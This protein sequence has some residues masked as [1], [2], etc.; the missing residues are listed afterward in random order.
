MVLERV[1]A[2]PVERDRVVEDEVGEEAP[3]L[4]ALGRVA[5]EIE[6][7]PFEVLPEQLGSERMVLGPILGAPVGAFERAP[8]RILRPRVAKLHAECR[9]ARRYLAAVHEDATG[10]RGAIGR[11]RATS[12]WNS[13][14]PRD[15]GAAQPAGWGWEASEERVRA[16][17][18]LA[19]PNITRP[20][21]TSAT[22]EATKEGSAPR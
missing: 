6:P 12:L 18:T 16:I 14:V 7:I 17:P 21:T 5:H 19:A 2:D 1:P 10:G 8:D 9:D 20:R 22:I 3:M 4:I 11:S 15:R 13:L